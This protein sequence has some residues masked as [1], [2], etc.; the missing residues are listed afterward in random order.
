MTPRLFG[1]TVER[2]R[3][4]AVLRGARAGQSGA[5][6]LRGEPGIGKSALLQYAIGHASG[7]TVLT[8]RG[9]ESESEIPF[10]GLAD[11][12]RPALHLMD[13][14]PGPQAAALESAMSLG[15]PAG[16][17]RFSVCA[18]TLSMLAAAAAHDP[19]LVVVDDLHWLDVSSREAILF[20][21]RRLNAEGIALVTAARPAAV[22]GREQ[23][24]AGLPE[25]YVEGLTEA[26]A[27]GLFEELLPSS[28]PQTRR[29]IYADTAGNPLGIRELSEHQDHLGTPAGPRVP[30]QSSLTRALSGRLTELA[31][32]TRQALLLVAAGSGAETDVVLRAAGVAGLTLP[33][34]A[35]AERAGLLEI[36]ERRIRFRHPLL[37][38]VLYGSASMHERSRAH[39]A[40]A[41]VLADVPGNAA[42]DGRAWHLAAATIAPDE[43]VAHLL[44][45]AGARAR[46]RGGHQEAARA[47][48]QAAR[49]GTAANRA[50][51]LLRAARCWQLS[52]NTARLLP[53]LEEALPLA[54]DPRLRAR[55]RHMR[56]FTRMW[57]THPRDGLRE[58]VDGA[59]EVQDVDAGR[60]ALMY[61]DAGIAYFMH[62]E[63]VA[64]LRTT[65]RAYTVSE[66]AGDDARLLATV[67]HAGGLVIN[68]RRLEGSRLLEQARPALLEVDALD[69]AQELAFSA[70]IWMWLEDHETAE[71]LIS[72]VVRR[73]RETGAVGVMPQV[74]APAAELSFRLG[75]WARA[76]AE[77]EESLELARETRQASLYGLYFVGRLDALQG[78]ESAA[79]DLLEQSLTLA[80]G[81]DAGIVRL[82]VGHLLGLMALG[83][84]DLETA[85]TRL[86][87]VRGLRVA[88]EAGEQSIV[89]WAF[90]LV[91]AYARA[92]RA[93][94]AA[95]LLAE[96]A[97]EPV[98]GVRTDWLEAMTW[99]CR[100]LLATSRDDAQAAFERALAAHDRCE[101][102]FERA[103]TLLAY[104]ERL[105]R[106]RSRA[107]A[108]DHLA[109]AVE[110]FEQLD[111]GS[112]AARAR[113]ELELTGG[114][115]VA[116]TSGV[117]GQLTPQE[118][119]VA[120]VVA[121]G[122]S[123][124]EAAAS[125]F[126][127]TKTIEYHL[128]NI[129]RKTSLRSR[130]DLTVLTA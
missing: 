71:A 40:L 8:A 83:A 51:L 108:R 88:Q 117:A 11:L 63:P 38:T 66:Q 80:D 34:F 70:Y 125:L 103:R 32:K 76:R 24:Y 73:A 93:A 3:I 44:A 35:P 114:V 57:R 30:A 10:A 87:E 104:G 28:S 48:E 95:Q 121:G 46:R 31:E 54:D 110:I 55:V 42:A 17:D 89:P 92:G 14:L 78:R 109:A 59:R 116:P 41:T 4:D 61:A 25:L 43:T 98:P 1:R 91:E 19:L 68:G 64:L 47:Y 81:L 119:K 75:R 96:H 12:L 39:G 126:L 56:G 15:P 102:P 90:D 5:L 50:R 118:L 72:R 105:R 82:Y 127:S 79:R 123:N 65:D 26:D 45:A 107:A 84:G 9:F 100:G 13:R 37:R 129:Y 52:G 7:F 18:A 67:A 36:D 124:Q 20:A 86:E 21:A 23:E 130:G 128:S 85:I 115:T 97:V 94:D 53:L 99:R 22:P 49:F 77:A 101:M 6:V 122:A 74:L 106:I 113:S 60:A 58:L 120:L 33:D 29:R 2:A 27:A 111:A 112:W 16:G 69:H 62:G